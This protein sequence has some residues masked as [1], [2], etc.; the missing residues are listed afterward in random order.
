[1]DCRVTVFR[2]YDLAQG[3]AQNLIKS[4]IQQI[5][6]RLIALQDQ[7]IAINE[8]RRGK[9]VPDQVLDCN[10]IRMDMGDV[11]DDSSNTACP[12]T[13]VYRAR[14]SNQVNG[15]IPLESIFGKRMV[16]RLLILK[17]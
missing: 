7:Q 9:A 6:H 2:R 14:P 8:K 1:M 4:Q 12:G 5:G 16:T 11:H 17:L 3:S 15:S 10:L 13:K